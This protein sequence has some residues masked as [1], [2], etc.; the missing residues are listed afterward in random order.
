MDTFDALRQADEVRTFPNINM[1]PP[2][3]KVQTSKTT[4]ARTKDMLANKKPKSATEGFP[5]LLKTKKSSLSGVRPDGNQANIF[6]GFN[7]T[8]VKLDV[9]SGV[10]EAYEQAKLN[11]PLGSILSTGQQ[12]SGNKGLSHID[13]ITAMP[14]TRA[15]QVTQRPAKNV[16]GTMD[17]LRNYIVL[18]DKYSLHNFLIYEGRTLRDTPEFQSFQRSYQYKWGAISSIIYQLEEFLSKNDVKLAIIN[19]PQL[20]EFAK[21]NLPVLK[22]EEI[23][24]CISNI[25]QIEANLDSGIDVSRKQMI[26]LVVKIQAVARMFLC[27]RRYRRLKHEIFCA[28]RLQALA[29]RMIQRIKYR[30]L[31]KSRR[32]QDEDRTAAHMQKLQEWWSTRQV[33]EEL[34]QSRLIIFIPS[35][36][37]VEYLRLGY[38]DF[39][40]LQNSNISNLYQLADPNV[41]MIYVVPFSMNSYQLIYHEKFL[42]LLGISVLP[43]RLTFITPEASERLPEHLSLSQQLWYSAKALIK[44]RHQIKRSKN[45]MVVA[46]SLGWAEKRIAKYLDIPIL[47]VDSTVADTLS[48]RSFLKSFFM[49]SQVNIPIGAHDIYSTDDLILALTRLIA[50]NLGVMRWIIRLNNDHNNESCIFFDVEKI[51]LIPHLRME[52]SEM[53]GDRENPS[54]WFSRP[55]Q[56]SVRKRILVALKKEFLTKIRVGRKDVYTTWDQYS[57]WIKIYGAV[58]EAEPTERLGHVISTCYINPLGEVHVTP[59]G[60]QKNLD[61]NYQIQSYTFPQTSTPSPALMGVTTVLA[62]R[63]YSEYKTIGYVSFHFQSFWDALDKQPRLW[64]TDLRFGINPLFGAIGTSAIMTSEN[65]IKLPMSL[66]PK[67]GEGKS[68]LLSFYGIYEQIFILFSTFF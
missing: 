44:I 56:I 18:M 64:A 3:F 38:D 35:I 26:R 31:E 34:D 43:K 68:T 19:G 29:R 25:D 48:S 14:S 55:I 54:A 40:A 15:P 39:G 32:T 60:I 21:L 27:I 2:V 8:S 23:Y 66:L 30:F 46:S 53:I 65:P 59:V 11:N 4:Y 67:I 10:P 50:S 52:Q 12:S 16:D 51:A 45:A 6:T 13:L 22:K 58:I 24:A 57:R 1:P 62:K 28:T 61:E 37:S 36:S 7:N 9:N 20:F 47:G 17:E 5:G 63:L 49:E 42:A 33:D 41:H